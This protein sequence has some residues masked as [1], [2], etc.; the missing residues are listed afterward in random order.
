MLAPVLGSARPSSVRFLSALLLPALVL[1]VLLTAPAPAA[2]HEAPGTVLSADLQGADVVPGP[3]DADAEGFAELVIG[4]EH[5]LCWFL[6]LNPDS[7]ALPATAAHV[8][9]G[10]PGAAGEVVIELTPPDAATATSE[11]CVTPD[12]AVVD[13]LA[14]NPHAYYVDVHNAEYPDGAVRGQLMLQLP[15]LFAGLSGDQE[16][17]GPGD[18]D[19]T[20]FTAV[21]EIDAVAGTLCWF[22]EV[23]NIAPATA[24]HIHEGEAGVAGPVVIPLTPPTEGFIEDCGTADPSLLAAILASPGSYYVNVHNEEYPD[25]AVR[26]QLN[27]EPP[28]P[29][30]CEP[31]Q[32]CDGLVVP[33]EYVWDDFTAPLSFTTDR[34]W[35]GQ[36]SPD[37][38]GLNSVDLPGAF[39]AFAVPQT[40]YT[41]SCGADT[42]E[43][44]QTPEAFIEHLAAHPNVT[45]TA[46]AAPASIGGVNGYVMDV[47]GIDTADCPHEIARL[48]SGI[49]PA[50][51]PAEAGDF[52]IAQ[53]ER[54]RFWVLDAGGQAVF[55]AVDAFDGAVFDQLLEQ[56]ATIL[57]SLRFATGAEATPPQ[58]IVTDPDPDRACHEGYGTGVI[59]RYV[60]TVQTAPDAESWWV[61]VEIT[62]ADVGA[63]PATCELSLASYE[64]PSARLTFPQTVHDHASGTFGAGTHTLT[65]ELPGTANVESCFSQ[66]DFVFGPPIETL[67]WDDRFGD[68]QLRARIVGSETCPDGI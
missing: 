54:I 11:G 25:G 65:V 26:G 10:A 13:A 68:R 58:R 43:L 2:A 1:S 61:S 28:P 7:V 60:T 29:P 46:A 9:L 21:F 30:A 32:I 48:W 18:P 17:P 12:A 27:A 34:E 67:T 64:L 39:Y 22:I 20:G 37:G 5:N 19:G 50:G 55:L 35:F 53:D 57:A 63:E 3:G 40:G 8:H 52:V 31:P 16:V 59:T 24:A 14:A 4:E 44:A 41:G 45:V 42:T 66:Y 49:P 15:T 51:L 36:T 33:G 47:V 62:I 38:F 23:H 6:A 56:A